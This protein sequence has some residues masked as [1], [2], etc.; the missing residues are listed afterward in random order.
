MTDKTFTRRELRELE[1]GDLADLLRMASTPETDLNQ[2]W[3][4]AM[5]LGLDPTNPNDRKAVESA[6]EVAGYESDPFSPPIGAGQDGVRQ[7][8]TPDEPDG[9][10]PGDDQ[11]GGS[12][13]ALGLPEP[14][15]AGA[16]DLADAIGQSAASGRPFMAGTFALYGDP[17]GA[18]V[19]VTEDAAENV[20]RSVV[21]RKVVRVA[22]SLMAGERSGM[23]GFLAKRFGRG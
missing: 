3:G 17:S 5:A 15:A 18:V 2:P 22:L 10:T 1:P 9:P 23:A 21:P 6:W 11:D 7:Y 8:L 20:R 19:L 14:D 4:A 16:A 12:G 13:D